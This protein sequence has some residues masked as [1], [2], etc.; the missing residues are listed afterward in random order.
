MDHFQWTILHNIAFRNEIYNFNQNQY[1]QTEFDIVWLVFVP[2]RISAYF[3]SK[4]VVAAFFTPKS[5]NFD[6]N[7]IFVSEFNVSVRNRYYQRNQSGISQANRKTQMPTS[8][9]THTHMYLNKKNIYKPKRNFIDYYT[10][11]CL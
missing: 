8:T 7:R 10:S 1:F 11:R 3:E 2:Y 6:E 9:H 4:I 5:Y